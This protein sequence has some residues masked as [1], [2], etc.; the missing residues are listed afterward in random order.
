MNKISTALLVFSLSACA[1]DSLDGL[2]AAPAA[3]PGGPVAIARL[4]PQSSGNPSAPYSAGVDLG[5]LDYV[6][7]DGVRSYDPRDPSSSALIVQYF[8]E[9]IDYPQGANPQDFQV[10]GQGTPYFSFWLPIAGRYVVR[11]TVSNDLGAS[12][13]DTNDARV[14]FDVIPPEDLH[15][16]LVWDE[17][18]DLD[19]HLVN[20]GQDDTICGQPWDCHWRNKTPSWFTNSAANPSLDIDDMDGQGPENINIDAPAAGTYRIYI[21]HYAV[22]DPW[23][24][25]DSPDTRATLR[26][27]VNGSE[28]A[29]YT[30]VLAGDDVWAVADVVWTAGAGAT[31]LPYASDAAGQPGDIENA[32]GGPDKC[33]YG[34]WTF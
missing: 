3:E 11:L 6:Y 16:Q 15:L 30:R 25:D 13:E 19:L 17:A 22:T 4:R 18:T 10:S 23:F 5:P 27:Y 26:I 33:S 21:H 32:N 9:I 7:L 29:T 14:D 24:G 20:V 28:A 8:W 12:S 34:G 2:P 31:I 1:Q